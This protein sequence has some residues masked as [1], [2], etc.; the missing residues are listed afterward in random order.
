MTWK[1]R[2]LQARG[3]Q[4]CRS[5][6]AADTIAG[7]ASWLTYTFPI[8]TVCNGKDAVQ[9]KSE[10]WRE[11]HE[12]HGGSIDG[13]YVNGDEFVVRF[14]MDV[15]PKATGKRMKMDEVGV[16]AVKNGKLV[17]ERF[18]YLPA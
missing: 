5:I 10:W 12:V 18:Y 3:I 6:P 13:P 14:T 8:E 9:K 17:S 4:G 11:N 16:Y 2:N 7:V 15:T 1:R